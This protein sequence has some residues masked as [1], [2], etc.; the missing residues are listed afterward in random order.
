MRGA[1]RHEDRRGPD[2]ENEN[3]VGHGRLD[4][5]AQVLLSLPG[6]GQA[7]Q[8]RVENAGRLEV[9]D[10][11]LGANTKANAFRVEGN[12]RLEDLV[13]LSRG[14]ANFYVKEREAGF[15]APGQ[16][17]TTDVSQFGGKVIEKLIA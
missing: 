12:V 9:L 4:L 15:S 6:V 10:Q 11:G 1:G 7:R 2:G 17:T 16:L 8:D 3:R 5:A 13:E 14:S